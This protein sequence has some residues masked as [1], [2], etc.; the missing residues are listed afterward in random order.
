M[1]V[2][3]YVLC[4]FTEMGNY[5][6]ELHML[7]INFKTAYDCS[8]LKSLLLKYL[9]EVGMANKIINLVR[10][11]LSDTYGKVNLH[12]ILTEFQY[13]DRVMPR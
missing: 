4:Q 3:I 2:H 7:Y 12:N 1:V 5:N 9:R 8:H 6:E 10:I 13:Y 11:K